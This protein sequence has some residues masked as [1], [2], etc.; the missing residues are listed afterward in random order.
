MG[1]GWAGGSGM[2]YLEV[3][4]RAS[5]VCN[6]SVPYR[7][8]PRPPSSST[9]PDVCVVSLSAEKVFILSFLGWIP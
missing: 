3:P 9:E 8:L 6:G 5:G 7:N 2:E 1:L 4:I